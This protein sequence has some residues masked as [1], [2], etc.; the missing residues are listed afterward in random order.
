[1]CSGEF[2]FKL[3]VPDTWNRVEINISNDGPVSYQWEDI[4]SSASGS[5]VLSSFEAGLQK[6]VI[7][8][9]P[10]NATVRIMLGGDNLTGFS[11]AKFLNPYSFTSIFFPQLLLEVEQWGSARWEHID[12]AYCREL[13]ITA[14]DIPDL[15]SVQNFNSLFLFCHSLNNV[16]N[17]EYW[18]V[19]NVE[20]LSGTFQGAMLFNQNISQWDVRKVK[21]FRNTFGGA[22]SFNQPLSS[23]DT[24]SAED[25]SQMFSGASS[26]NQD[27][28]TWSTNNVKDFAYMFSGASSFNQGINS[29]DTRNVIFMEEM[30]SRAIS[31]NQDISAWDTR[32]V[33]DMSSMFLNAVSF[34][35]DIS[36]WD[37]GNVMRMN[38]MF[39]YATSFNQPISNWDFSS[40]EVMYEM[41]TYSG[42]DCRNF[43]KLLEK[44]ATDGLNLTF[45]Q[46]EAH[47]LEYTNVDAHKRLT[48]HMG[49]TLYGATLVQE[50]NLS[51]PNARLANEK[52]MTS[53]NIL[54]DKLDKGVLLYPNPNRGS[55]RL[56][57]QQG[58]VSITVMNMSGQTV[59]YQQMVPEGME[60]QLNALPPGQYIV[61]VQGFEGISQHKMMIAGR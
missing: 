42:L 40:V 18:D 48:K 2:I 4:N 32:N 8:G 33:R 15:S 14:R 38:A 46:I 58:D 36:N 22:V 51:P 47:G 57:G 56:K 3:K 12:F 60:I 5:G 55:F 27:I 20:E 45:N 29:W 37:V 44:W 43:D 52:E 49:F 61:Q 13:Q 7:S 17:I 28:N 1:M 30:F 54:S 23:W 41:I 39:S 53:L 11:Y 35:Q 25:M 31:F 6:H 21:S 16:P 24:R 59:H 26:F 50:C 34:N 9:M 10:S 19:S